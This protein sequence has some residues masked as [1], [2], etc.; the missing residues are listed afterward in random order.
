VLLAAPTP[1][2]VPAVVPLPVRDDSVFVPQFRGPGL[3]D[4]LPWGR[5]N[6]NCGPTSV[7]NALRLVG[8]DV[9][10]FHGERSQAVIDAARQLVTGS[11]DP[12]A[13]T[14]KSQQA[15]ALR[16]AGADAHVTRSLTTALDQ[17]RDGAVLLLGGNRAAPGWPR[18]PDDAK[19]S[20]VANHAVVVARVEPEQGL[21]RVFDPALDTPVSVDADQ[22]AAFTQVD[23][24]ARMLRLGIV[25]REGVAQ[26]SR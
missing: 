1:R 12:S 5:E 24:A 20:G 25:V 4:G 2:V 21:F 8:R 18:R 15:F 6:G 23:D 16:A 9:P 7:V 13:P 14:R 19:P 26:G 10:G 11:N 17:V 3:P 22:L